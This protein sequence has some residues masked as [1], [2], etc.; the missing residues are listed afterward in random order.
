[1]NIDLKLRGIFVSKTNHHFGIV[2]ALLT[3]AECSECLSHV[4]R[5]GG[6]SKLGLATGKLNFV[7]QWTR[8]L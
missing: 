5:F 4:L 2:S 1:M 8:A 7:R 3:D 6:S